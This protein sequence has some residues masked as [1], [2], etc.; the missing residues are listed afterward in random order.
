MK[1]IFMILLSLLL[2]L[3]FF[4][5]STS[6]D[7]S[8]NNGGN[9]PDNPPAVLTLN[10]QI[11]Q[12]QESVRLV[13]EG[14]K[15][16]MIISSDLTASNKFRVTVYHEW[17]DE[18]VAGA[19]ERLSECADETALQTVFREERNKIQKAYLF[20]KNSV[21]FY[22]YDYRTVFSGNYGGTEYDIYQFD[23]TFLASGGGF[24]LG[25]DC[26]DDGVEFVCVKYRTSVLESG[27]I[28][29]R[30]PLGQ[31][32]VYKRGEYFNWT[33]HQRNALDY[34]GVVVKRGETVLGYTFIGGLG[35][36]YESVTFDP[37][38]TNTVT[39]EQVLAYFNNA[40]SDKADKSTMQASAKQNEVSYDAWNFVVW[41][42]VDALN[43]NSSALPFTVNF[44]G[45]YE[46][47]YNY[48]IEGVFEVSASKPFSYNGQEVTSATIN[49]GDTLMP[50]TEDGYLTVTARVDGEARA[51]YFLYIKTIDGES[52]V[53]GVEDLFVS[54]HVTDLD[55]YDGVTPEL[56]LAILNA[57]KKI[58]G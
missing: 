50:S 5:C 56:E 35:E 31:P 53:M 27:E 20:Y 18:Q 17:I 14:Q 15:E 39:E 49:N 24:S 42:K 41:N 40:L 57:F 37:E 11:N 6:P 4:A 22:R 16:L 1:K 28:T 30:A 19:I 46:N 13:G 47:G 55:I 52:R 9:N 12:K 33:D 58:Y 8:D 21:R 26:D 23:L 54:L 44:N 29:A 2:S 10:E 7:N 48:P 32:T 43:F 34:A 36:I 51:F 25:F 38:K 3:S 45:V